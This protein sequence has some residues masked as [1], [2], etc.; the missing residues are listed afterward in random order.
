M[1]A[2]EALPVPGT[3]AGT[4]WLV[5]GASV[6]ALAMSCGR[7]TPR[8]APQVFIWS[9][10][11]PDDLAFI[12]PERVGVAFLATTIRLDPRGVEVL[13]RLHPLR[14]PPETSLIAVVRMEVTGPGP[15]DGSEAHEEVLRCLVDLASLPHLGGLQID[16]DATSS[17]RAYY[18]SLLL[19]LRPRLPAGVGLSITA[20]AS[21]CLDDAWIEGLPVDEAVPMLFRM[22]R[23]GPS[24]R[25]ALASGRDFGAEMCR[26]SLGLSTDEPA[27]VVR[28][29]RRRFVFHTSSWTQSAVRQVLEAQS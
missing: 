23:D 16:F 13:P 29:G 6:L 19:A 4:G 22:G 24:I 8:P 12:D 15:S 25:A 9:W 21:W 26:S 10:Q 5:L 27:P 18:R 28:S 14:M 17:Q 11:R 20:L 3:K 2:T 1:M 7:T